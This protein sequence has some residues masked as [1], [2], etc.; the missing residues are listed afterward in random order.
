[1]VKWAHAQALLRLRMPAMPRKG[2]CEW[3]LAGHG[4]LRN[5]DRLI[6]GWK[7][8]WLRLEIHILW[9]VSINLEVMR[10]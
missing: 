2:T 8:A 6:A 7:N 9:Q 3:T 5:H 10:I 1:M 4:A